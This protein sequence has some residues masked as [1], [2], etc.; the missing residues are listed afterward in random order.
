MK[1]QM[2]IPKTPS[3]INLAESSALPAAPQEC[4]EGQVSAEQRAKLTLG[5]V[6]GNVLTTLK[7]SGDM[8]TNDNYEALCAVQSFVDK[9]RSGD[10]RHAESI[11][12]AQAIALDMIWGDLARA[13][14]N[15]LGRDVDRAEQVLRLGLKAQNQCRATLETLGTLISPPVF[16]RQANVVNNGQQQVVNGTAASRR[17]KQ[18]N[19]LLDG[20]S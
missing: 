1:R 12:A 5:P 19:E 18:R 8:G 17:K 3:I 10:L 4:E 16:A 11:L 9:M 14:S 20:A 7:Y 13:A 2:T 15:L 6:L